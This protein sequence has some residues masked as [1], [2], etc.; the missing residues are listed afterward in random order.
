MTKHVFITGGSGFIGTRL[1]EILLE[2]NNNITV[3]TR[4]P[5]SLQQRWRNKIN[6]ISDLSELTTLTPPNWVINLA[7]EPIADRPWTQQRKARLIDSRVTLT[8]TL[9]DTLNQLTTAPEVIISG[10]A[11]GYYDD[12][13]DTV[14]TEASQQG[15]GFAAQLCQDWEQA[16]ISRKPALSRLCFLRTGV[17]LGTQGGMLKKVAL[18][19][20]F[21][22]G[23]QLGNGK[24]W[25]S[26]I[27]L[28]DICQLILF[29]ANHKACQGTYNATSPNPVIN[30][31]FTKALGTQL[32][33]PTIATIPAIILKA[34][35][36]E[37]ASLL[38][39][40]QR[41]L[42]RKAIEAGFEFTY[43]DITSCIQ[44]CFKK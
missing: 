34:G 38:L 16:A 6:V 21:G 10:S 20:K 37:A 14:F 43:P 18:P 32:R 39:G 5:E 1:C 8:E 29:L 35:L 15:H 42:P 36:G 23:G 12:T 27:D 11:I 9:F 31:D 4:E 17:V 40:S 19:F 24:Q 22:I 30:R 3:L 13:G 41:I 7:G 2:Q 25:L 33:R 26:W 44:H 28:D